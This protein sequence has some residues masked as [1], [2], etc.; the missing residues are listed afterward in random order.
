MNRKY[1]YFYTR[2]VVQ[3]IGTIRY[4]GMLGERLKSIIERVLSGTVV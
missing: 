3:I 4:K 1:Y 2:K